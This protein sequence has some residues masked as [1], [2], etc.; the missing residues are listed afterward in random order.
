MPYV[1][2]PARMDKYRGW[3]LGATSASGALP[4]YEVGV[5]DNPFVTFRALPVD[6]RYRFLLDE[7]QFFIMNFIKGPVCRGQMAVDVIEDQFWVV[8]VDPGPTPRRSRR[9]ALRAKR[10]QADAAGEHGSDAA[11]A[12]AVAEFCATRREASCGT[13]AACCSRPSTQ[14]RPARPVADLGRRRAQPQCRADHLPPLRQRLGGEGSRRRSRRRPPGSSATRCS[15]A[16]T[17]CWSPV[18]TS[19]ATSAT[20]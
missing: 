6:S 19:T 1:L 3:F 7:A 13:R 9:E 16:S 5:A 8:F 10:E 20:S 2:S 14:R 11:P 15:S 17:T 18:T 4:S 12:A